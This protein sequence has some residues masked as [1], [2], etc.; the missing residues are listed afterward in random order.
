M[1]ATAAASASPPYAPVAA[2]APAPQ[3]RR[4][5]LRATS[6]LGILALILMATVLVAVAMGFRNAV[7]TQLE[8]LEQAHTRYTSLLQQRQDAARAGASHGRLEDLDLQLHDTAQQRSQYLATTRHYID[9][10]TVTIA[11]LSWIGITSVAAVALL[12][13]SRLAADIAA[14]RQRAMAILLG[15]RSRAQALTRRDELG[16]LSQAVEDLAEALGR[17]ERDLEVDRRHVLHQEKL[18]TIGTMAAGVIRDIGNPI[19]AIDG[20]ARALLEM[21]A[22]PA[23]T[24]EGLDGSDVRP[25]LQETARLIAITREISALAAAPASEWQLASLNDIVQQTVA[26]LRYEPRFADVKIIATLDAQL[27]AISACADRLVQLL[28]NLL[29]NAADATASLPPRTAR[30]EITT[31]L[32]GGGIELVVDDNGCGLDDSAQRRAFEPLFTTKPQGIGSGLGLPLCRS[33][34]EYHGGRIGLQPRPG[35]G[36]RATLWLPLE[37]Q[38]HPLR[39]TEPLH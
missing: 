2:A 18:A 37:K 32:S 14:V 9:A 34:A 28:T 29:T 36:A 4:T 26:L 17:R 3:P 23:P 27:P 22:A 8:S 33:I 10:T 5:T 31:R 16:D 7:Q 39:K 24:A 35:G 21:R 1:E 12:F 30:V 20:Y 11:T 38:E 19:A 15:D 6:V 13:F 25:I